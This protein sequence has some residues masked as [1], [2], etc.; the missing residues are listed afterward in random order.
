MRIGFVVVLLGFLGG[1]SPARADV[2]TTTSATIDVP[3]IA[4]CSSFG[5][6]QSSCSI[7][8]GDIHAESFASASANQFG[9][10]VLASADGFDPFIESPVNASGSA[11]AQIDG[12]YVLYGGTG[13]GFLDLNYQVYAEQGPDYDCSVM[14]YGGNAQSCKGPVIV[15]YGVPFIMDVELSV[16]AQAAALGQ[17][18]AGQVSVDFSQPGLCL[19]NPAPA[20]EPSSLLLLLPGLAGVLFAARRA[21]GRLAG[22]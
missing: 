8:S 18:V 14:V 22:A 19:V 2:V 1:I 6:T 12:E 16:F 15:E 17:G 13:T 21:R 5:P 10:I 4:P 3:G 7:S 9:G 11:Q 20:P